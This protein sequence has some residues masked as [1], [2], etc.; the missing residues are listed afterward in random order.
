MDIASPFSAFSTRKRK[1]VLAIFT[2]VCICPP[3]EFV[4]DDL[5]TEEN[6]LWVNALW[7]TGATCSCISRRCAEKLQLEFFDL[8]VMK[9]ASHVV[10]SPVYRTH[11]FLPNFPIFSDKEL[12]E[13]EEHDGNCDILCMLRSY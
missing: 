4:P 2:P 13:F 5:S 3:V 11:L 6:S 9:S 7:D 8:T 1:I 10:E 12:V